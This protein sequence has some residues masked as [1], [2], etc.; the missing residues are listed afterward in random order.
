MIPMFRVRASGYSRMTSPP[1]PDPP[2][3]C[4]FSIFCAVSATDSRSFAG[5]AISD[6]AHRT[7]GPRAR[8]GGARRSP[9]IVCE[10]AVRLRHL[11]HVLSALHRDTIAQRGVHDL[12]DQALGHRVLL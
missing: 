12:P 1:L 6:P 11:V 10:G 3:C 8:L 4:P 2:V 9:S 5:V 7:P